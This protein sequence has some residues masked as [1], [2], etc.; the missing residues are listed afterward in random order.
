MKDNMDQMNIVQ[1]VLASFDHRQS[2][3][4]GMFEPLLPLFRRLGYDSA[5][6]YIADDY[7]D[8]MQHRAGYGGEK[9]FPPYIAV[10]KKKTLYDEALQL[11]AKVPHFMAGRLFSHDRELGVILVTCPEARSRAAREAFDTLVKA[12]SIMA[13]IERI[14]TNASREREEREIFFA[15]S[16]TSRLL[17]RTPP[18]VRD[19]RLGVEFIRSLEAG[20]DFF[21]FVPRR[22]G[23]LMGII[24]SCSGNGLRTV[25]EVTSIMRSLYRASHAAGEAVDILR[26]VNSMLV[27]EKRRAHQASLALFV[28]DTQTRKLRVAKAGRVGMLLC[29]PGTAFDNISA[30]GSVYLGMVDE[31]DFHEEEYDFAPGQS[32]LCVTEG[33]YSS[34]NLF[35]VR[36]QIHWFL[37]AVAS[38]LG[39]RRKKP[40]VN[41]VMDSVNRNP[42]HSV[43]PDDSMLA[44]SVEFTGRRRDS[45]RVRN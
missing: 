21:D 25:L 44:I 22:G 14:R 31:P 26:E 45:V 13:Y 40:L 9:W 12:V 3:S 38:A 37:E 32:L 4:P 42:D 24:G 5:A 8:R 41:A 11:G 34:S 7:P 17:V 15:Q 33:F 36:P 18:E 30:P 27:R 16:L 39:T 2:F 23:G 43:R 1:S 29:G 10:N 6:V 19:L 28:V 35:N 20:G